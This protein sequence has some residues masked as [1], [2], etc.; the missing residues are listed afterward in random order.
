[1][2][3]LVFDKRAILAY[4]FC[5][6]RH[7]RQQRSKR[8]ERKRRPQQNNAFVKAF[9]SRPAQKAKALATIRQQTD[10]SDELLT[11][12]EVLR[13]LW[14]LP[15]GATMNEVLTPE[16]VLEIGREWKWILIQ[17]ATADELEEMLSPASKQKLT[18]QEAKQAFREGINQKTRDI[19]LTMHAKGFDLAVIA[20]IISLPIDQVQALV[21]TAD[22][23]TAS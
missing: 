10:L 18:E 23:K 11:Y 1:M 7:I 8:E 6:K 4:T 12:F 21:A 3:R 16:R 20:D 2:I 5:M 13:T 15:E 9:A 19:V 14:S 22:P 17:H